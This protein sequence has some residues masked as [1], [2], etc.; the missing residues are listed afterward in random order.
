ML[1]FKRV[2][3]ITFSANKYTKSDK[4]N[5]ANIIKRRIKLEHIWKYAPYYFFL[6]VKDIYESIEDDQQ[7]KVQFRYG[8]INL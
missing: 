7:I 5:I 3:V 4:K 2:V 1:L 8:N 6:F